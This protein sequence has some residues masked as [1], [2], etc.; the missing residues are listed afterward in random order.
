[1]AGGCAAGIVAGVSYNR[2]K[3]KSKISVPMKGKEQKTYRDVDDK[4]VDME[5][6]RKR[7]RLM[8]SDTAWDIKDPQQETEALFIGKKKTTSSEE[9]VDFNRR[10]RNIEAMQNEVTVDKVK[11]KCLVHKGEIKGLSYTCSECDSVYCLE[12][13]KHLVK[14]GE[15]CWTC[16]KPIILETGNMVDNADAVPKMEVTVFSKEIW[17]L[18]KSLDLNPVVHDEVIERLKYIPPAERRKY[19]EEMFPE[20]EPYHEDF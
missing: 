3:K 15:A 9:N 16:K 6:Y 20:V 14:N 11:A 4:S 2:T 1:I 8:K 17:D 7:T 12:C 5:A 19:L 18:L 13:A 10:A